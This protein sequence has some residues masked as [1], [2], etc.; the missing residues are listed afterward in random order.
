MAIQC[1][2]SE[3]DFWYGDVYLLDAYIKAYFNNVKYTA[4]LNGYYSYIANLTATA[5]SWGGE[6]GKDAKYPD[7][8]SVEETV[9]TKKIDLNKN[10]YSLL[11]QLY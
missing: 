3:Q 9:K 5:N 6:K 11:S 2:M 1:G 7:F 10:D 8:D 4:W